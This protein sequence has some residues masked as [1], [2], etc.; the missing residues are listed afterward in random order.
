M[1]DH[2]INIAFA[3]GA[4][5]TPG[6]SSSQYLSDILQ[7]LTTAINKLSDAAGKANT[8]NPTSESKSD[9]SQPNPT[10]WDNIGKTIGVSIAST[11]ALTLKRFLD[12][13]AS[14][15]MGKATASGQ[16]MASAIKGNANTSFGSY[17]SGLYQT[18]KA[19]SQA[20]AELP[21]QAAG[22]LLGS[23]VG[24]V[25]GPIGAIGGGYVGT[26]IGDFFS[27]N[28]KAEIEKQLQVKSAMAERDAMAS[29]SQWKTGFSRFG[30]GK[31]NT[32]IVPGS[33]TDSGK[34]ISVP[35][36][37][38]F[39]KMYG[40]DK[41]GNPNQ[42]F[43][44]IQN[45]IAPYLQTNPLDKKG[46]GDLNSVAQNFLKAGFAAQDF[47]KLTI[48]ST[49]Y[50]AQSGNNIQKFSEEVK[51]A[52]A[53]FGDVF[54]INAMQTS[55]NLMSAGYGKDQAQKIA[56]QSQT[57]PG[58]MGSVNQF[59]T[60]GIGDWYKNKAIGNMVGFDINKSLAAGHITGA[61]KGVEAELRKE[62]KAY[63]GGTDPLSLPLFKLL[64][65]SG[66]M[67]SM[68]L[69]SLLQPMV[70]PLAHALNEPET[71]S[72][73][74]DQAVKDISDVLKNGLSNVNTMNVTATNVVINQGVPQS[75]T[76]TIGM[77]STMNMS[78]GGGLMT[79]PSAYSPGRTPA[80]KH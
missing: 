1:A 22:G 28:K 35:L 42:N 46:T 70:K 77:S 23:A 2:N 36:A 27:A 19:K 21:Y 51:A 33:L 11:V 16:F 5:S 41:T 38:E 75:K 73:A 64:L 37:S 65:G 63:I 68:Q 59:M 29:V 44:A 47:A 8:T 49:Q 32:E 24:S 56:F 26:G 15:I 69:G 78:E 66:T 7:K 80:L 52:R 9:Q 50:Q 54:D 31:T 55:L 71:A 6:G 62:N 57:N 40:N 17:V 20:L 10:I 3:G 39:Q 43:N 53:K 34:A 45:N 30:I 76:G 79:T 48:Q 12:V 67:N 25:L 61:N 18:D 58:M 14:A 72:P 74:Q 4:D 60:Q 13:E